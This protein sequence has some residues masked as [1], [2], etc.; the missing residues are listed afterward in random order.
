MRPYDAK[1]DDEV[2][3]GLRTDHKDT[4]DFWIL[5]DGWRVSL[6]Q[7]KTGHP[8]T[9]NITIPRAEFNKLVAWYMR[10]QK[11]RKRR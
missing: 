8:S 4:G 11:P 6:Y 1:G 2:A 3:S 10:D 5:T 9:Q 7:Q